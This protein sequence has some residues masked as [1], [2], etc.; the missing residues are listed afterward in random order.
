MAPWDLTYWMAV[1]FLG[2]WFTY[3]L[4]SSNVL[5]LPNH[6]LSATTMFVSGSAGYVKTP[7]R[8]NEKTRWSVQWAYW[9]NHVRKRSS[10]SIWFSKLKMIFKKAPYIEYK[11]VF[12]IKRILESVYR[13]FQSVTMDLDQI[14]SHFLM[15]FAIGNVTI[16][17]PESVKDWLVRVFNL[18]FNDTT[19]NGD[20]VRMVFDFTLTGPS[21]LQF[22]YEFQ[23][24]N[25]IIIGNWIPGA[26]DIISGMSYSF[27]V[28]TYAQLILQ[29]VS[30]GILYTSS[31][32]SSG[33][34][35]D[36]CRLIAN[37]LSSVI[38]TERP[39]NIDF[40]FLVLL[41]A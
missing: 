29:R 39:S 33:L 4:H 34:R 35:S 18:L 9:D 16:R 17:L 8:E 11:F 1:I 31:F 37:W 36:F 15:Q 23:W 25:I 2:S 12:I 40:R 24:W 22:Q 21:W 30:V 28:T 38:L 26:R 6:V 3:T 19:Q 41:N 27:V 7:L 32:C 14:I 20:R 13:R 10:F 5:R